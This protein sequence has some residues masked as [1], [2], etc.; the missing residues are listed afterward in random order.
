MAP[1]T[2]RNARESWSWGENCRSQK[3]FAKPVGHFRLLGSE[4]GFLL[5]GKSLIQS[6]HGSLRVVPKSVGP[7]IL[8]FPKKWVSHS[9]QA[10]LGTLMCGDDTGTTST[11][12]A[13]GFVRLENTG[14]ESFILNRIR[15]L[16]LESNMPEFSALKPRS[17]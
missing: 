10:T 9:V 1:F 11:G 16:T 6:T 17:K 13:L 2:P 8:G 4:L 15:A 12:F 3:R 14:S 7:L 5:Q